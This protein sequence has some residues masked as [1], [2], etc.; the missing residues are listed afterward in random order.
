[1]FVLVFFVMFFDVGK[2]VG[3]II[4]ELVFFRELWMF[5]CVLFGWLECIL[6]LLYVLVYRLDFKISLFICVFFVN[7][8]R[9]ENMV[10]L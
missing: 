9:E 7:I 6:G 3:I 1:M 5:F 4:V 8:L 10:K 2:G